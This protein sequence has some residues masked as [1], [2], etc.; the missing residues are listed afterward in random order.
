MKTRWFILVFGFAAIVGIAR[1]K[2]TQA[3]RF[4]GG[5]EWASRQAT[6]Q[7]VK[8]QRETELVWQFKNISA[9][10]IQIV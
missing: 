4:A 6:A 7:T 1:W 8:G 3:D 9:E 5:L 10:P 2:S